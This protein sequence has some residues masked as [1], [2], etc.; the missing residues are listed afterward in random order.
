MQRVGIIGG[1]ISG[2]SAAYFVNKLNPET[3]IYLFEGQKVGGWIDTVYKSGFLFENGPR[4][5]RF[6][7][8]SIPLLDLCFET[9]LYS[10]LLH[11][12]TSSSDSKVYSDGEFHK[13]M[14]SGSFKFLKMLYNFP[15]YRRF[16]RLNFKRMVKPTRTDDEDLDMSI[17]DL[18]STT[19]K[20]A[21]EADKQFIIHTVVDAFVQG[22]YSG[23]INKLSAKSCAPFSSLLQRMNSK[24][25]AKFEPPYNATNE[26]IHE[27]IKKCRKSNSSAV[28]LIGGMK[29]LPMK[30]FDFLK[31]KSN[32]GFVNEDVKEI[33]EEKG[34][35]VIKSQKETVQV[36]HIISTIPSFRLKEVISKTNPELA[37]FCGQIEH[38]SIKNISLGFEKLNLSG[39]GFLVPSKQQQGIS[40]VLFD[41]CS[42]PYLR[43]TVS[44]MGPC[45]TENDRMIELFRQMTGVSD[46]IVEMNVKECRNALPQ[47]QIG[48]V[49]L[50]NEVEKVANQW[51]SVSGQSF[52]L[53]GIPNCVNRSM[54]LVS[55][56]AQ[57]GRLKQYK[58]ST[59]VT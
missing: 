38:R 25:A 11:S 16:I 3:E 22:V 10:S 54:G 14:P 31:V 17:E 21:S 29:N 51:L 6:T 46:T 35:P 34:K 19:F 36:D 44:V 50:V 55:K 15:I 56:L 7:N 23:H 59:K 26:K 48:H 9:G 28:N 57:D 13:I 18:F 47:Y 42:F 41:S 39:V 58:V 12:A 40:G 32:F 53:S 27:F 30:L 4:S 52:Y 20:Y 5:F 33:S 8:K 24:K 43:P 37:A 1:G 45:E 49:K 2:L